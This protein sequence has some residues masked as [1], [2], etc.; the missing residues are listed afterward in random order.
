MF[1]DEPGPVMKFSQLH[2]LKRWHVQHR[3]LHPVENHVWD[4]VLT[5][6]LLGMVGEPAS[7]IIGHP[8]AVVGCVALFL[9]PS[10]YVA[11]RKR[12]HRAGRLRCDW[13]GAVA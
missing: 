1:N 11:L 7:L 2:S 13:L 4:L 12:L 8:I 10:L 5:L 6:W 9:A 3:R